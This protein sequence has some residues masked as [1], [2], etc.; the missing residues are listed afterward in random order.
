[1]EW[2]KK[3][4]YAIKDGKGYIKEYF[5]NGKLIFE[6]EYLKGER[7][8]KG[9]EYDY[10]GELVFEGEYLNGKRS[11]KGKDYNYLGK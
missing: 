9:K 5:Y 4:I 7:N 1:M 10:F 2:K 6:G 11:G 3:R 8:G